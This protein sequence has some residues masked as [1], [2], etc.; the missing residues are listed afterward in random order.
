MQKV[1]IITGIAILILGLL[2]PWLGKLPLGR[3]PGDILVERDSFRFYFPL[4]TLVLIS[5]V[6]SLLLWFF[7]R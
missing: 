1:L 4:T 7:R 3:L 2:W 5:L 6:V